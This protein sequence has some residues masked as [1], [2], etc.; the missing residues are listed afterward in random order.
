M[1]VGSAWRVVRIMPVRGGCRPR[2]P[3]PAG[4]EGTPPQGVAVTD[5]RPARYR[6]LPKTHLQHVASAAALNLIR[7]EPW[8]NDVPLGCTRTSHL[9][10]PDL[11][12]AA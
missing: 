1:P 7:L 2:L 9:A 5:T 12:L 10:R 11:A 8:F 6:G 4:V 3:V